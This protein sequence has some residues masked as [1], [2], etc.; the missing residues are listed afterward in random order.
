ML[1]IV[2]AFTIANFL[3]YFSKS[4]EYH[5]FLVITVN[6]FF[7]NDHCIRFNNIDESIQVILVKILSIHELTRVIHSSL[8]QKDNEANVN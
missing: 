8:T 4:T 6:T 7:I 2:Y 5:E 3:I 1:A